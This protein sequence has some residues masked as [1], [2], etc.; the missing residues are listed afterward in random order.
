[1]PK[2]GKSKD[3]KMKPKNLKKGKSKG[4][5]TKSEEGKSREHKLTTFP[6]VTTAEILN[7]YNERARANKER[8][9]LLRTFVA[10]PPNFFENDDAEFTSKTASDM[11]DV[12]RFVVQTYDEVY[13]PDPNP[14]GPG[15]EYDKKGKP[16]GHDG[17]QLKA[18]PLPEVLLNIVRTE[19]IFKILDCHFCGKA[20]FLFLKCCVYGRIPS[21]VAGYFGSF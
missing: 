4:T 10:N 15:L 9:K 21:T 20:L 16:R 17:S 1:M 14:S 3:V 7:P 18:L 19:T 2:K 8:Q 11:V 13:H 5:K 12:D 6:T